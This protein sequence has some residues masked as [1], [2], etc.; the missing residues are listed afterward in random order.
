[1]IVSLLYQLEIHSRLSQLIIYINVIKFGKLLSIITA[2]IT[3]TF[4]SH[5]CFKMLKG[6]SF[7]KALKAFCEETCV[8]GPAY[9]LEPRNITE[10]VWWALAVST[11]ALIG[12][13]LVGLTVADWLKS[14]LA[15]AIADDREAITKVTFPTVT[16]CVKQVRNILSTGNLI[17]TL[18]VS[19][20]IMIPSLWHPHYLIKSNFGVSSM[21]KL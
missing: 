21:T 1:M 7:I 17:L 9:L 5:T 3:S 19:F 8:H 15:I 11:S 20:R 12:S 2:K 4:S 16:I 13:I 6:R 10:L 14:P 18:P